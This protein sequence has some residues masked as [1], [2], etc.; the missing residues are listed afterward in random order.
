[1]KTITLGKLTEIMKQ[2]SRI[3]R[4]LGMEM[5]IF[6]LQSGEFRLIENECPLGGGKLSDGMVSGRYLYSPLH[7]YRISLDDGS[8]DVPLAR[9]LRVYCPEVDRTSGMLRLRLEEAEA[10]P[11]Y[12][13]REKAGKKQVSLA[14]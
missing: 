11:V 7:D 3:L 12:S 6:R 10:V 1:M 13:A 2:K 4:T 9:P 8:M 5:A 14:S